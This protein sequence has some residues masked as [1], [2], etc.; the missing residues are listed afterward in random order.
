M[1][2]LG[3]FFWGLR[4]QLT[5]N[6][7][8]V[9]LLTT[10]IVV[11]VLLL[12]GPPRLQ[13]LLWLANQR[14]AATLAPF[15]ADHYRRTGSWDGVVSLLAAAGDPVSLD[16]SQAPESSFFWRFNLGQV[17]IYDRVVLVDGNQRVVADSAGQLLPGQP[18]TPT[19]RSLVVPLVEPGVPKSGLLILSDL[20]Q[21]AQQW[22]R[23]ALVNTL[24]LTGGVA[25]G[26]AA[27]V[28]LG[29]AQRM[30]RPLG[31]LSRA[32]RQL[33]AGEWPPALPVQRADEVGQLTRMFNE[34]A[35]TLQRQKES[36]R[37]M[38]ADIAH[39]LR[40]PLSVMKLEI[41]GLT[42][43][44]QPPERAAEAL[45]TEI[46]ALEQLIEDLRLLSLAEAGGLD[47]HLAETKLRP[48]LTEIVTTW[49][50]QARSQQ[51]TL[52][53]AVAEAL[54]PVLADAR[55]LGQVFHNL[56]SNALRYT[57]LG[58]TITLGGRVEGVEVW[59]W[60]ADSGPGLPA[61]VLP[62]LFERF[63]RADPSRS[64]E[65]GG[66]GL[67]LAIAR[68]LVLLHGG[69]IWAESEQGAVFYVAL[70]IS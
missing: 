47:L 7:G 69:R 66:S 59:L 43:G 60:L 61:E 29:L 62:H 25:A 21:V 48:L 20:D 26:L 3:N 39:E 57:P 10:G 36:R 34:M 35:Q 42:D 6:F 13:T 18:L 2:K 15:L 16:A 32:A 50:N 22:T 11:G 9:I 5:R 65:T 14:R 24:L 63:Y 68:Q 41:E 53:L 54:P 38:M 45:Q 30:V 27:L 8:L 37:Q 40:T 23:R 31:E 64:R 4:G 67:G 12:A 70:P 44:L 19:M 17:T 58:G 51:I 28:S 49:Q 33:A 52:R 46:V 55:R 56:V 1:I